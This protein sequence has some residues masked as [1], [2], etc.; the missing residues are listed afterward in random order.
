MALDDPATGF[1]VHGP[2]ADASQA[3]GRHRVNLAPLRFGAGIKGKIVDGWRVGL[4]V[5]TTPVGAEGLGF[6]AD[7]WGGIV[8]ESADAFVEAAVRLYEDEELRLEHALA[9]FRLACELFD[10]SAEGRGL[11]AR[12]G[13]LRAGLESVRERNLFGRILRYQTNRGTEYFSR[14]I[15]AKNRLVEGPR[16]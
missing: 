14:W 12:V 10:P 4:P 15:E 16:A 9:G 11:L 6:G 2:A 13:A 8:A 3:M 5:V 7:S 1:R